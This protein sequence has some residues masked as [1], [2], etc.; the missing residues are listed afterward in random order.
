M[1][2]DFI[3]KNLIASAVRTGVPMIVGWL[4][5]LPV[6]PPLLSGLGVDTERATQILS[7][8]FGFVL[9]YLWWLLAR[10]LEHKWPKLGWLIGSTQKPI[11]VAPDATITAAPTADGQALVI[12]NAQPAAP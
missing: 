10:V 2:D 5:A 4:L 7:A 11:Y 9:A 8:L 1:L 3:R 12:T 6:V